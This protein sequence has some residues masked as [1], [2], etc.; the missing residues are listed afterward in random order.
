MTKA[1]KKTFQ[2]K[3]KKERNRNVE[4][5]KELTLMENVCDEC[6]DEKKN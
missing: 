1:I 5:Q 4:Y 3:G 2:T 6:E